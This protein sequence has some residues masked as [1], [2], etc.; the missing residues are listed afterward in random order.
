MTPKADASIL[1][2]PIQASGRADVGRLLREVEQLDNFLKQATIRE[3]GTSMKLPKTSRLLDEFVSSNK[4]NL[5]HEVD[6]GRVLNF[7][8]MVKAKAPVLHMSFSVDPAPSFV[9]K[10]M[11]WLRAE[12]HPLVLLQV[13][14]QPNIGAGCVV[15]G[16][17]KYF[18]FSL[19]EHFKKQRPLLIE[20]IQGDMQDGAPTQVAQP[21][22]PTAADP[23]LQQLATEIESKIA[24]LDPSQHSAPVPAIQPTT[25]APHE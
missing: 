7:L 11:T 23:E 5:L 25:G 14:L 3:P 6:R 2:L 13:G 12:V 9:Q 1:T 19:R 17:N 10:L 15:R 18:D 21:V 22:E 24:G 20:K 4:L 16:T 8:I